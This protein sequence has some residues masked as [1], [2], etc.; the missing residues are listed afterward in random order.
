M[1]TTPAEPREAVCSDPGHACDG[2]RRVAPDS[3]SR[4]DASVSV[5]A[6][7]GSAVASARRSLLLSRTGGR[8]AVGRPPDSRCET[9]AH[10]LRRPR[11]HLRGRRADRRP[12]GKVGRLADALR[13]LDPAEV[14][15]GAVPLGRAAPAARRRLGGAARAPAPAAAPALS[16]ADVDA[17]FA[18]I[19]ALCGPGLAGRAPRG[20]GA[21]VRPRDRARAA[22]SCARCCS[23]DLRQGALEGVMADAVARGRRRAAPPSV[24]RAL[25]LRGDLGAVAATALAGGAAG[26]RARSACRSAGRVQPMLASP[27]AGRRGRAGEHRP[28][29]GRVEARRRARPGPPRRRRR[30]RLHP[31]ARRRHRARAGGRRGRARAA[32]ARASCS[33]ARRSRC[34]RTGARTRSRRPQP[35]FGSR[36]APT[37]SARRCSSTSCTSTARTCSTSPGAE[38]AAALEPPSRRTRA[39]RAWSPRT[40]RPAAP[41]LADALARGHEGVIVKALDAP[42]AAGRRG[43]A[44]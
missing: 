3:G 19:G 44:G 4:A 38:R 36:R 13:A 21:A 26:A 1:A 35:R 6:A 7:P 33:T 15:A 8:P 11:R 14:A 2:I 20:A 31:H 32:G 22:R 5:P 42:Y 10:A 24:R 17:A 39:C 16:V 18:R 41:A 25:M 43:A 29:R 40:P 23:G 34:A 12:A 9:A 27:A 28:G 30:R 37:R